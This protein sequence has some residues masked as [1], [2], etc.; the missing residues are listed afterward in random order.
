MARSS[1]PRADARRVQAT[2]PDGQ[3]V[4]LG[5]LPLVAYALKCGHVG[6]DYAVQERDLI[7]CGDCG[8]TSAVNRIISR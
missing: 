5:S 4:T 3:V 2:G 7:F 6:R 8:Q 1:T